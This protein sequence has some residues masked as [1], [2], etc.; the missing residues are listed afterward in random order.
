[1]VQSFSMQQEASKE[2]LAQVTEVV[3]KEMQM[4]KEIQTAQTSHWD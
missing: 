2:G 1:M 4:L 3:Q